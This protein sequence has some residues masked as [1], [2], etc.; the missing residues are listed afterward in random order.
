M[1]MGGDRA[2]LFMITLIFV[3]ATMIV[4]PTD[5]IPLS[6]ALGSTKGSPKRRG[7]T[8]GASTDAFY[9]ESGKFHGDSGRS[10]FVFVGRENGGG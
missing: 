9:S 1:K 7:I 5:D 10:A 8:Q 6:W 2:A 3:A 4:H